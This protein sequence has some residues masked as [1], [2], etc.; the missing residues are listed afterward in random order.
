VRKFAHLEKL[1]SY[2]EAGG[3]L[4]AVLV[5]IVGGISTTVFRYFFGINSIKV[6]AL[7]TVLVSVTLRRIFS[8]SLY[9][10]PHLQ[11]SSE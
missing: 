10:A 8:W 7:M 9:T 3:Y 2:H 5:L 1:Q 4:L 6:Q 11:E